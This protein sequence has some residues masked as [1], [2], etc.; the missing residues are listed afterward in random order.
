MPSLENT[1]QRRCDPSKKPLEI[2][3]E[4]THQSGLNDRWLC[5]VDSSASCC[6]IKNAIMHMLNQKV[7]GLVNE[8][9]CKFSCLYQALGRGFVTAVLLCSFFETFFYG[10][11]FFKKSVSYD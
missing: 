3:S 1:P 6:E 5:P 7:A 11:N 10:A 9:L 4:S 8:E 2:K